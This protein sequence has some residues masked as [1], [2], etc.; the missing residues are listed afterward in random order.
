MLLRYQQGQYSVG[1]KTNITKVEW[2]ELRSRMEEI[3]RLLRVLV[4]ERTK[5]L[6]SR[7]EALSIL[8]IE[9]D[10]YSKKVK[11]GIIRELP[12]EKGR[13]AFVSRAELERLIREGLV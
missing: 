8:G 1:K 7:T 12:R 5:E 4:K 6:L 11:D 13:K 10:T 3:E 9:R 2:M